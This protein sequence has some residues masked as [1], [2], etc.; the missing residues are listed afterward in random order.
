VIMTGRNIFISY[1]RV[2][3]E[4]YAGRIYD[5]FCE[6]FGS[7]RV[8]LDVT[9][10]SL[11]ENFEDAINQA[12]GSC[13]AVI[14]IIGPQWTKITD[15]MGRKRL[16]DPHDFI[17]LE[18]K[19]AL[20]QGVF[21]I[22]VLV[23]GAKMPN[24]DEVPIDLRLLAEQN[25]IEIRA[26]R[27]DHDIEILIT[28][29]RRCLGEECLA[30]PEEERGK[31]ARN[32]PI[33]FW[34]TIAIIMIMG[35]IFSFLWLNSRMKREAILAVTQAALAQD[36]ETP[37]VTSQTPTVTLSQTA[38]QPPPTDTPTPTATSTPTVSPS[39]TPY[40]PQWID[41]FGVEMI[42]I[43][44]GS[45]VMGTDDNGLWDLVAQPAR[46]VNVG[47]F[48]IDKYEVSNAQ[49]DQCVL[50]GE[51]DLPSNSS[52]RKRRDYFGDPLYA[53]YPVVFVSWYNA[54]AYCSWRG[55]RLPDEA[56]W[57]KAARGV[58]ERPYPWGKDQPDCLRANFWPSGACEGDTIPVQNL[59]AG[60]SPYGIYNM[61]GNVAEWVRDWFQSYPG[62]DPNASQE[63]GQTYRVVRGGAYFDGPDNII[64]T[65]RK[66]LKPDTSQSYVG[67]RC[68]VD[69][70]TLP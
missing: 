30:A 2:D 27:F 20:E 69:I 58:D 44:G 21:V 63:Y 67:F 31:P 62:G 35:I 18:V 19:S 55:G 42:L 36:T 52:S 26:R 48:Y 17:H 56:E 70:A 12:I 16:E 46:M 39:P 24:S 8:F 33:W 64:L 10:I 37:T 47:T 29:I 7:D 23:H 57:E 49:Y 50:E 68:V 59:S 45:F 9:D 28:E 51:C 3:S 66:G 14:V 11:E 61:S 54:Q 65:V 4:G 60:V 41:P 32:I 43:Q 25:A 34:L 13:L 1:R 5:R 40:P 15:E 6:C 22:P 38:T 53:D